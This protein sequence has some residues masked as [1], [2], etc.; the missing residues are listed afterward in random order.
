[1]NALHGST[2]RRFA[3]RAIAGAPGGDF[4]RM[5]PGLAARRPTGLKMARE[6]GLPGGTMDGGQ[7]TAEQESTHLHAGFTFFGQFV[8][9][10]LTLEPTSALDRV[11]ETN[12]LPDVRPPRMDMDNLYGGGPTVNPHL[13]D[14]T[15][16]DTKLLTSP[17]GVDLN[18]TA[19]GMAL[20]GDPRNDENLLLAQLHLAFVKF[21]N[22]VVDGLR[23][24][25]ITD[26]LGQRVPAKPPDEPDTEQD[27]ATLE[28]LLDV[29]NY[30]RE[31]FAAA[32][33]LVRWHYQWII[34][35]EFLPMVADPAVV[36]DV[37]AYGARFFRPGVRPFIPIEFAAAA[38]RFGHPT[39]RSA[40][41]VNRGF[42]GRIFPDDPEAPATPRTDLRGGPVDAEH[43][44][45]WS[46]LFPT[47]PGRP[48]QFAR[49]IV[50]TLNT[51]LLDLPVSAVPGAKDGALARPVASLAVCNLLRSEALGLPSGQDVART[52]GEVPLTDEDLETVGPIYLWYYILKEAEVVAGGSRL[53]PVGSRVVAEVLVGL[54]DA[55]ST[56]F[57]ATYSRWQPTLGPRPG[58]FGI[59]D[60]L[61][62]A[63]IAP[64]TGGLSR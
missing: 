9:H 48:A 61:R 26:A 19:G 45:D 14:R 42:S 37:L 38:F 64:P 33:Q 62:F 53:G 51:Q 44:V 1:M 4:G 20:I 63:G 11:S 2:S 12:V 50:A 29:D 32:R 7:T 3:G 28:Q 36:E 41:R 8:D 15:S 60:L 59:V 47:D 18:R 5:F 16:F 34:V 49:K 54:L 46:F 58:R 43:A 27:G 22:R 23:T 30:H 6:L 31:V 52:I 55:D 13:Y 57:R 35:H 39:V 17:D 10:D 25:A 40:Y 56:S 24:D 21:H